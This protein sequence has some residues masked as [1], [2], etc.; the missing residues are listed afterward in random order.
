MTRFYCDDAGRVFE[1]A[2]GACLGSVVTVRPFDESDALFSPRDVNDEPI[3]SKGHGMPT[4]IK[5]LAMLLVI[6]NARPAARVTLV[7]LDEGSS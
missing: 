5:G 6:R 4:M 1:R 2:S 3:P 7:D